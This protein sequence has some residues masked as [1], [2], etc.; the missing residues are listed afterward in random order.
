MRVSKRGAAAVAAVIFIAG[1]AGTL[2]A[3]AS[4]AGAGSLAELTAE[5]RQ[6]RLVIEQSSRTQ[7][8]AQAL[9]IFL[10]A[11]QSRIVQVTAR[12]DGARRELDTMS[13]RS[14]EHANQLARLEEEIPRLSEPNE[15]AAFE[16]RSRG[17]KLEMKAIA[18]QEQQARTRE[19]E[20][21]QAWQQEEAR[22]NDLIA[23]LQQ[24][25]ER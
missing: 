16:D 2:L 22:W 6:L 25:V 24:I 13:Q 20:M 11:Q 17:L 12:L 7:T 5:I 14:I 21:L 15:R 19:A 9:G 23:R 8:Q 18:T 1:C 10:S 4:G 3:Q